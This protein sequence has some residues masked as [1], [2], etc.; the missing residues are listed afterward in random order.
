MNIYPPPGVKCPKLARHFDK[1]RDRG[2]EHQCDLIFFS[3]A[4][5]KNTVAVNT[6]A[7][8][9]AIAQV[10]REVQSDNC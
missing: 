10:K 1:A 7:A 6:I 3:N 5:I 4:T 9:D 2:L 8:P